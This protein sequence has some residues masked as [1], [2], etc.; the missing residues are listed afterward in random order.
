MRIKESNRKHPAAL[1]SISRDL[2]ASLTV[3][4]I[5]VAFSML[6]VAIFPL[7]WSYIAGNFG[8]CIADILYLMSVKL[9]RFIPILIMVYYTSITFAFY[10]LLNISMQKVFSS[11]PYN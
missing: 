6:A 11:P 3:V 2:H 5:S 9:L 4:N 7:W 8:R 10:Y 1:S